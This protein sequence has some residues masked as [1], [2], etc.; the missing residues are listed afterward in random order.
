MSNTIGFR[1]AEMALQFGK[2]F[3]TDEALKSG[4][5]DKIVPQEEV[6]SAAQKEMQKWLKIP[7][8]Y[9]CIRKC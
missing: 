6:V 4:L 1:Q 2:L 7:S 8:K 9:I 5:I 3:K